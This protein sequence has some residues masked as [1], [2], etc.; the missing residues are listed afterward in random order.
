MSANYHVT[1]T[2]ANT[3]HDL[4]PY[5]TRLSWRIGMRTPFA[6]VAQDSR[7]EIT[8]RRPPPELNA[9]L[10]TSGT[11]IQIT[12]THGASSRVLYTGY[13]TAA[14][15]QAGIYGSGHITLEAHALE[16]LLAGIPG[17]A[18]LLVNTSPRHIIETALN[19]AYG[20]TFT[21][22]LDETRLLLPYAG[23]T[24]PESISALAMIRDALEVERGRFFI[25]REGA[26][27]FLNRQRVMQTPPPAATL[28]DAFESLT[29]THGGGLRE[30][31]V[32]A[33]PRKQGVPDSVLWTL[34]GAV[35]LKPGGSVL[36]ARFQ[37][38]GG[39]PIGAAAVIN[40]APVTDYQA[41]TAPDGT[42]IDV[43]AQVSAALLDIA[44][45]GA[46]LN[47]YNA[48][49]QA[50]YLLAGARLRGTP[51]LRGDPVT[52]RAASTPPPLRAGIRIIAPALLDSIEDAEQIARYEHARDAAPRLCVMQAVMSERKGF[53]AALACTLFDVV[54]LR[55]THTAHDALY[56]I[57]A[58]AHD[59][60][61]G[62]TRHRITW[63]LEPVPALPY[64]ALDSVALAD[65]RL[66]C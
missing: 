34:G 64:W 45:T 38:E 46:R 10:W 35:R 9:A 37:A 60:T 52:A 39:L 14:T 30:T 33:V 22:A 28:T 6:L 48:T 4:T 19:A 65:A 53:D 57:I 2:D 49:G 31:R 24:W 59:I 41:N 18:P 23:D 51:L 42:G 36:G 16:Y 21:R 40:P 66:G 29:L 43:T 3:P 63:T 32:Q 62:G 11:Q 12:C 8:L 1:L 17:G 15:P 20:L 58:E 7:A 26:A 13:L 56:H 5:V 55:E 44:G 54:R 61:L 25:N 50:V 27:V 47:L